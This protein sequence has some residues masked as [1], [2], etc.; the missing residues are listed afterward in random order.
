MVRF[1]H[2]NNNGSFLL[3]TCAVV[4]S[5]MLAAGWLIIPNSPPLFGKTVRHIATKE[6][7]VALTFD[8]GPNPPYTQQML[9]IL[10]K[11][12]VKATFFVVGQRAQKYPEVVQSIYKEGHELG[13]HT[14]SHR[15]LVGRSN[16]FVREEIEKTDTL[17]RELGYTGIIHFRSPKGMKFIGLQWILS[18]QRRPNVLFDAVGWDW[19][20]IP[21]EKITRNVVSNIHRGSIILLHDG[22]GD[23]NNIIADRSQTVLAT[24]MIIMTL[25]EKGYHF[26]TV[27]EL[28]KLKKRKRQKV[29]VTT[30]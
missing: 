14:W 22:N 5:S 17:I 4:L 7:V 2:S 9:E 27:S 1:K 18:E 11:H 20:N 28:L 15:V 6:K 24:E 25:K 12:C 30:I 10:K 29:A 8:D 19:Q 3:S 16:D 13:N 26:V 23:N 21:S